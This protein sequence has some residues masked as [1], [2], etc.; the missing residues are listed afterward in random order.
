M[1][2]CPVNC[3]ILNKLLCM[4]SK[5]NNRITIYIPCTVHTNICTIFRYNDIQPVVNLVHILAFFRHF[6]GGIQQRKI[7]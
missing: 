7:R 4:E 1:F 5:N 3:N 6:Q 2:S